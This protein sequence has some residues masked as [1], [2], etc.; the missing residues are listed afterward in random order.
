MITET[1]PLAWTQF[2][3]II[4]FFILHSFTFIRRKLLAKDG[5]TLVEADLIGKCRTSS[6]IQYEET[7]GTLVG[8]LST[9][10]A[11]NFMNTSEAVPESF[12]SIKQI[13]DFD[14]YMKDTFIV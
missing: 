14:F 5:Q 2:A 8:S 10:V 6:Y 11:L 7:S 3:L 1:R 4:K 12:F 9:V 13:V